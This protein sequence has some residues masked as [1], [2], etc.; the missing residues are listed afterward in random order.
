MNFFYYLLRCL[1]M[2]KEFF[3]ILTNY[4]LYFE[5]YNKNMSAR[6]WIK[7]IKRH[8]EESSI[9]IN[10]INDDIL[11]FKVNEE[12]RDIVNIILHMIRS[13]EYYITGILFD[14]W[15][16]LDYS[17]EVYN[18]TKKIKK[19]Y[20]EVIQKMLLLLEKITDDLL[21]E[22]VSQFNRIATKEEILAEMIEHSIHHR[23]QLTV[24]YRLKGITP[25]KIDYII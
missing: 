3:T 2:F 20:D 4:N 5:I 19:L 14:E 9:L 10:Q 13:Y 6:F 16:P 22:K 8:F 23:G 24:Y 17:F 12:T 7:T 15:K 1:V 11:D 18:N 25:M 21:N